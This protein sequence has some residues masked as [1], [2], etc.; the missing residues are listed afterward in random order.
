MYRDFRGGIL[1]VDF[2]GVR[3]VVTDG[4]SRQ[5]LTIVRGLKEIGC[6]VTV[7][8]ASKWDLC[9]SSRLPDEKIVNDACRSE[10]DNFADFALALAKSGKYDVIFPIVDHA[11]NKITAR[12]EEFKKYVKIASA[13]REAYIKAF[14]KQITFAKAAEL[15]IPCPYTRLDDQS[16]ED[17]LNKARFPV[18]IKPRQGLGS[19]GFHKFNTIEEIRAAIRNKAFD[20]D[21]YVIQECISFNKR[22][23]AFIFMDQDGE[24]KTSM[25]VDVL[26]WYPIDAGSSVLTKTVNEP[27][28]A[29]YAELLLKAL[30]W[31]GFAD[32]DFMVEE[33]TGT[34]ILM[35]I[36]GRIPAGVK[37][38]WF[39]GE[40]VAKQQME[41][42]FGEPVTAYPVNNRFDR[43]ARHFQA[44]IMW[45]FK[46]KDRFRVKPSWFSWRNTTDLV[47]WK[48]DPWP[49]F[50]YTF[51]GILK[52]K[53][54]M[55]KRRH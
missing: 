31:K 44:D 25:V 51:Q 15:G 47:F 16:V 20:P 43:Y 9:A 55:S 22:A 18:I 19:I 21:E 1:I 34:P 28:V 32:V 40:N 33:N 27:E 42:A 49:A 23:G 38:T 3:V 17:F 7:L 14:N 52:Y 8:C 36:N 53:S 10:N 50:V 11:T 29:R 35:E 2:S 30:G 6:N 48:D 46:S 4:S 37:M 12:E 24:V 45:F 39:C 54:F 13:P 41:L 5:T 26:R